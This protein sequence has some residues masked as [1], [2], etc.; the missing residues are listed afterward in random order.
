MTV[1]SESIPVDMATS[2]APDLS[3]EAL[4][5]LLTCAIC[6]DHYKD[7][8]MLPCAHSYCE[9]CI[10]RLPRVE[11]PNEQQR[12]VKCPLCQQPAQLGEKGSSGLPIAFHINQID[13]LSK[14]VHTLGKRN[15]DEH[16]QQTRPAK[17]RIDEVEQVLALFEAK[18]KEMIELEE[19]VHKDID[20]AYQA[21]MRK[22]HESRM[23]LLQE[24][25]AS[26]QEKMK[27]HLLQKANVETVL[28]KM[29]SCQEEESLS[30]PKSAK[31]DEFKYEMQADVKQLS[32]TDT[33]SERVKVSKLQ[34]TQ[35]LNI[36]F[37]LDKN[38]LSAC[39]HIGEI[40]SRKQ[41]SNS[42]SV[43][44]PTRILV[45]RKTMVA[46]QGPTSLEANRLSCE[47]Y[48]ISKESL[49]G[50]CPVTSL[51]EGQFK[52]IIRST[53]A[54]LHQLR[55][56]AD[57]VDIYGS[58]FSVRV[59]EWKK[60]SYLC[61]LASLGDPW[62]VAVTDDGHVV[63]TEFTSNC[64]TVLSNCGCNRVV[65]NFSG[66]GDRLIHPKSL[67]VSADCKNIF[68]ATET[69]IEKYCLLSSAHKGS[70]AIDCAGIALH[71]V[72]G[73]L[74]CIDKAKGNIAILN[75]DLTPSH[76]L[77]VKMPAPSVMPACRDLAIDSKG[78]LYFVSSSNVVLKFT[79][80]G[81][82]YATIGSAG[83][84]D[85]QFVE[86]GCICI[87]SNDIMYITDIQKCHIMMFTTEGD[88]LENLRAYD[89]SSRCRSTAKCELRGVAV[90]KTGDVFVCNKNEHVL[91]LKHQ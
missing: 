64:V 85:Y 6:L 74:Y 12:V 41:L 54:G 77:N 29:K 75:N 20:D 2:S 28:A 32:I 83:D 18:E 57:G 69:G 17:N 8:R 59:V 24:A 50:T 91:Y 27:L 79:P 40:N 60:Q 81:E 47:L 56:L 22:L 68:V 67:A 62:D 5:K 52:I 88:Y 14:K 65:R 72:S 26:L 4:S 66:F 19:A 82:Y 49:L 30:E 89:Y 11:R 44:L 38:A 61:K 21:L 43:D 36:M 15:V 80:E 1:V 39:G 73:K 3:K 53:T 7:P 58:P 87:D 76:T 23:R 37:T 48:N 13:E 78:M 9:G 25:T 86:P 16:K 45:D 55:V 33:H 84:Q 51:G 63:V 31:T 34:P 70:H 71:P 35:E 10:S 46:I 90:G 42:F